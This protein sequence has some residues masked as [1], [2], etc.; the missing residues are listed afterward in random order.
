MCLE[1]YRWVVA[2]F[3]MCLL[4]YE[5]DNAI[6]ISKA[7]SEEKCR[8]LF[9]Q[10]QEESKSRDEYLTKEI[11]LLSKEKESIQERISTIRKADLE[12]ANII[13]FL[14]YNHEKVDILHV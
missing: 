8:T 12:K 3:T 9:R 7:N 6:R 10:M 5:R 4:D 2:C 11:N 13:K 1:I 14:H